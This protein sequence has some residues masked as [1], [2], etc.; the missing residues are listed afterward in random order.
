MKYFMRLL[1]VGAEFHA[2]RRTAKHYETN[3]FRRIA[4]APKNVLSSTWK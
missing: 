4:K 1:L 3:S 2:D